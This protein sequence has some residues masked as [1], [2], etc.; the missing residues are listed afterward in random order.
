MSA[1]A[2][3][4]TAGFTMYE[5]VVGVLLLGVAVH[6]L[7]R[8]LA[9]DTR[10]A[11]DRRDR[12]DAARLLRNEA[13]L[14]AATDPGSVPAPRRY[15]A[16]RDGREAADGAFEVDVSSTLRCLD[17]RG[18]GPSGTCPP[19]GAVVDHRVRVRLPRAAGDPRA[20]TLVHAVSVP[21]RV[22]RGAA[23]GTP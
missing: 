12:L 4:R 15:R 10:M 16:G 3:R 1:P 21:L 6:P 2:R 9:V 18:P 20:D 13:A 14:R 5:V 22:P 11:T 8:T 23:G 7:V 17:G 19:G